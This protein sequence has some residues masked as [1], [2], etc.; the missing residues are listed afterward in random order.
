MK[1]EEKNECK[2][3]YHSI[4][5][6]ALGA[7]STNCC[8]DKL[9]KIHVIHARLLLLSEWGGKKIRLSSKFQFKSLVFLTFLL[10]YA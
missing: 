1:E 4:S 8:I 3:E 7:I 9:K 10:V 5:E 6:L 2:G